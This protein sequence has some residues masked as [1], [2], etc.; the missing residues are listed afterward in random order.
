MV[1]LKSLT[2]FLALGVLSATG[3]PANMNLAESKALAGR[4]YA[5]EV[6]ACEHVNW[7]GACRKFNSVPGACFNVPD[8]WDNLISSIE[9]LSKDNFECVWWENPDCT[10]DSFDSQEDGDLG[11]DGGKWNDRISSWCCS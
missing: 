3:A 1:S 9:N 10:G 5:V 11:A 2:A 7:E 6:E 4:Q 8:D